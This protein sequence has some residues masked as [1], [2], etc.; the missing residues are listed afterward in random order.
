MKRIY[1]DLAKRCLIDDICL[2]EWWQSTN[3]LCVSKILGAI[4]QA[5]D[6]RSINL[7][8]ENGWKVGVVWEGSIRSV[9]KD[10][11]RVINVISEWLLSE[12]SFLEVI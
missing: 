2:G 7:L 6:C 4:H 5:N 9:T 10:P 8:L 12:S 11:D 1:I 3:G